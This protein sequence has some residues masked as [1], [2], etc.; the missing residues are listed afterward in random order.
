MDTLIK[1]LGFVKNTKVINGFKPHYKKGD[2]FLF[3]IGADF[4]ISKIYS[5]DDAFR[6]HTGKIYG[7]LTGKEPACAS[8]DWVTARNLIL[9][10]LDPLSKGQWNADGNDIEYIETIF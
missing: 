7:V 2:D 8:R 10:K 3:L 5:I 4:W 1:N 9:L 6:N